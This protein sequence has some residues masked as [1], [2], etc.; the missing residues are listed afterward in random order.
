[1]LVS[2]A[3][4]IGCGDAVRTSPHP[5]SEGVLATQF[6]AFSA[7]RRFKQAL[8]RASVAVAFVVVATLAFVGCHLRRRK[9]FFLG[10][11]G[12]GLAGAGLGRIVA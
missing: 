10:T 12:L 3:N 8:V 1:M 11:A 4:R 5:T 7:P 6:R 9:A 2:E